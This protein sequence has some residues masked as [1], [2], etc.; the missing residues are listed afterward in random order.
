MFRDASIYPRRR[1]MKMRPMP[2][3]AATAPPMSIHMER[4]VGEPVKVRETSDENDWDSLKPKISR[5]TPAA[6]SAIPIA[7]FIGD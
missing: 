6:I 7:V 1:P 4:S 3:T 2:R 5:I